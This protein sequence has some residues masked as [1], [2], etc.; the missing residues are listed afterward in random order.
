MA[1][2]VVPD[3]LRI[4]TPII[5]QIYCTDQHR[6]VFISIKKPCRVIIRV[7]VTVL[8]FDAHLSG[9]FFIATV[10]CDSLHKPVDSLCDNG[11]RLFPPQATLV[12]RFTGGKEARTEEV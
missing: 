10:T 2:S 11:K 12:T 1:L 8:Y 4:H 3:A 5:D 7:F 9:Q 6:T